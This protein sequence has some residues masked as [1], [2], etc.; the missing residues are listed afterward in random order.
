MNEGHWTGKDGMREGSWR[1]KGRD[2]K[3]KPAKNVSC[4]PD[5]K[6]I[7]FRVSW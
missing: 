4:G 1:R 7:Q 5:E 3:G 2:G 6:S